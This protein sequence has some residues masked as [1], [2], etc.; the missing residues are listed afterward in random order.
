M[1]KKRQVYLL[2]TEQPSKLVFSTSK[3]GGLFKSEHYSPMKEMGDTYKHIYFTSDEEIKEPC[4]AINMNGDTLYYIDE[5]TPHNITIINSNWNK[6]I[7]TTNPELYTITKANNQGMTMTDYLVIGRIGDDFIEAYI[8]SY[9]EGKP[10]TEVFLEYT[11]SSDGR[12]DKNAPKLRSNGT[13]I[14]SKIES[15]PIEEIL[16]YMVEHHYNSTN[17]VLYGFISTFVK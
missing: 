9:N 10:I 12:L 3:Y 8:K 16:E 4:W 2:D 1:K 14:I 13:V 5:V 7:A 6:V 11:S 15:N 17:P